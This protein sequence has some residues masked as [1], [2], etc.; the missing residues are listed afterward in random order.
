MGAWFDEFD[1]SGT[2]AEHPNE[3]TAD[4][5]VAVALLN[6]PI[7]LTAGK[8]IRFDLRD[9]INALLSQIP[10]NVA[11]WEVDQP[12]DRAWP[13]WQLETLLL[14][15]VKHIGLT[16]AS[17]LIARKRPLL[18]P[19]NDKEVRSALQTHK[20]HIGP[21]HDALQDEKL[22]DFLVAAREVA[23]LPPAVTELRVLDVLVWMRGT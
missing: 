8:M 18:Y 6:T 23:G 3:F 14:T 9:E 12:I 2:R 7:N 13:A 15:K 5:L 19:I 11:L 21:L 1:P 16:R 10:T 4:D 22:R 20:S 17:K